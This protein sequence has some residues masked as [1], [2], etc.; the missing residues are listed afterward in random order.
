MLPSFN[1]GVAICAWPLGIY[2]PTGAWPLEI[3]EPTGAWALE[4]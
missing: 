3:C 4:I 2:E 1:C